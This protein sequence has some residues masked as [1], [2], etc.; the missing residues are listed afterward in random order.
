MVR[1]VALAAVALLTLSAA[2][3]DVPGRGARLALPALHAEPD[4]GGGRRRRQGR[5]VILR[6]VNVNALAEYWQYGAFP[7]TFPFDEADADRDLGDGLERRPAPRLVVARRARAR[8]YDEAYLDA[9]EQAVDAARAAGVYTID[10]LPPGRRGARR[11]RRGPDEVAPARRSRPL[12]GT[13]RRAGRRSTVV[14]HAASRSAAGV[15]LRP[16]SRRS[17]VLENAP[18]PGG[19]G[20][21]DRY[22]AWSARRGT[23][24][25]ARVGRRL[26]PHERAERLQRRRRSRRSAPSTP[27]PRRRSAP[28]RRRRHGFPHLVVL[29]AVGALVRLR[30]GTPP[31]SRTTTTSSSR[32]T[33]TG[34]GS[35][36]GRSSARTSSGRAP[37]PPCYGGAPVLVGEW[38][39]ARDRAR[40]PRTSTSG[41]TR[42]FQ[43]E[44]HFGRPSGPGAS[45]AATRTRRAT[46]APGTCRTYGASSR[47]T[48][49]PTRDG[50]AAGPARPARR[51]ASSARRPG[52]SGRR[53]G[54]PTA[55]RLTATGADASER[56]QLRRVLAGPP[57]R[58]AADPGNGP[59]PPA[60]ATRV[61]RRLRPRD[62]DGRCVVAH[63]RARERR[64]A[65][66]G[67]RRLARRLRF[68]HRRRTPARPRPGWFNLPV[69][70]PRRGGGAGP[71]PEARRCGRS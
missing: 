48:A 23:L 36:T 49:P 16:C 19:V 7:T 25:R 1:V 58:H 57:A 59:P 69:S 4:P 2:A 66:R 11:S 12:A 17:P 22:A 53:R 47:S 35:P 6:G 68:L 71:N 32:R 40:T 30:T 33:S 26:R 34:A 5:E 37:T 27:T 64:I 65:E 42:R 41:S 52:A 54:I 20:I 60:H 18:G 70:A 15:Q 44:F 14:R 46:P 8:D 55:G 62:R 63:R 3:Q 45:P 21:R 56:T 50:T 31:A 38:G 13:A 29:R 43:D 39:S 9:V 28:P 51:A 61:G 24:R 10:R 67:V